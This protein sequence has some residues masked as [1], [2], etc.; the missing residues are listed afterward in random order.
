MAS[1]GRTN[2]TKFL[3]W[4]AEVEEF[5]A[6]RERLKEGLAIPPKLD[7]LVSFEELAIKRALKKHA[8]NRRKAAKTLQIGERTLY[9]WIERLK[10]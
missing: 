3:A 7:A 9:R 2:S 5:A 10:L 6:I 8:N 4:I 1:D